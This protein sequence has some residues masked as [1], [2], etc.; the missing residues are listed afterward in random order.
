MSPLAQQRRGF[1]IAALPEGSSLNGNVLDDA[2]ADNTVTPV[3]EQ[4]AF[5]LDFPHWLSTYSDRDR[6]IALELMAG[7]QTLGVSNKFGLSPG[8]ISQMRSQFYDSWQRF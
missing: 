4:V 8:R 7:E 6:C 5:R 2:L 3:D 1:T